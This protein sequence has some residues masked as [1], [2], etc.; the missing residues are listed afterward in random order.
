MVNMG[1]DGKIA[2]M[3]DGM[4]R[5]DKKGISLYPPFCKNADVCGIYCALKKLFYTQT[6]LKPAYFPLKEGGS[7]FGFSR[8]LSIQKNADMYFYL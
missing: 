1:D 4:W 8:V 3:G 2:D 5:H 7:F 6:P